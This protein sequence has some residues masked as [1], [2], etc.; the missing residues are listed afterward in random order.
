MILS[1]P[2]RPWTPDA[3]YPLRYVSV[4]DGIDLGYLFTEAATLP[5][6]GSPANLSGWMDNALAIL[7]GDYGKLLDACSFVVTSRAGLMGAILVVKRGDTPF[8]QQLAV[9]PLHQRQ[10]I[11]SMLV[12]AAIDGLHASKYPEV[13]VDVEPNSAHA[14]MLM[15]QGFMQK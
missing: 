9:Q 12:A 7:R 11:G 15:N 13:Q 6:S 8:I 5:Q 2:T 14:S 10:G 4:D 3:M 1:M